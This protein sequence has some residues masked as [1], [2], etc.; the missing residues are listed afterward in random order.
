MCEALLGMCVQESYLAEIFS[1]PLA[2][3]QPQ[4]RWVIPS[5]FRLFVSLLLF[6][7]SGVLI[8]RA[9]MNDLLSYII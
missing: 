8:L 5:G 6:F 1:S 3:K 7:F 4:G 2:P 9:N